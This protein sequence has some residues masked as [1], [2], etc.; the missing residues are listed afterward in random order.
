MPTVRSFLSPIFALGIGLAIPQ[1]QRRLGQLANT[2]TS[3]QPKLTL[4]TWGTPN[5]Q[6]LS[7]AFEELKAIGAIGQY[8]VVP[9]DISKNMQK[10]DWYLKINPNGRIPAM[11]DHSRG[12]FPVFESGAMCL[13]LAEHYDKDATF[14]FGSSSDE[15]SEMYQWMFFQMSGLGPMFGQAGHF[16]SQS[17]KI[18][19]AIKRY[20]DETKRLLNVYE[21]RLKNRSYLAGKGDGKYSYADIITWTWAKNASRL[22]IDLEKEY[23]ALNAWIKRIAERPAVK[24]GI[25]IPKK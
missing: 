11:V 25:Q 21:G 3:S 13:Y 4:Y 12:D 5:G 14:H 6:K 10:E 9:I 2:M 17:N 19:Y 23:P 1:T 16:R 22:E 15:Q 7:I 18:E 20:V 8:E 24:E